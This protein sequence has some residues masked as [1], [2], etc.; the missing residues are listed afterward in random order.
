MRRLIAVVAAFSLL[1]A[2]SAA[3]APVGGLSAGPTAGGFASDNFEY[4]THVPLANDT[5]GA[6]IFGKYLYLT[7][8]RGLNIYDITDPAAPALTGTALLPQTPYFG[9]EDPDTNGKILLLNQHV[10][11][12]EDKTNPV[13]I[14]THDADQHTISCIL[15]CSWAYGSEGAIV[16]L[17]DPTKPKVVGDWTKFTPPLGNTHDVTEVKPGLVMTSTNPLVYLDARKDPTKPKVLAMAGTDDGAYMHANLW[18][19]SGKE[20]FLLVGSETMGPQCGENAGA[21]MTWDTKGWQKSRTFKLT[22]TYR[23]TNG[24]YTDGNSPA[25]LYC[26]HWFETH[27]KYRNGGLV[28]MAWYEHGVRLFDISSAGKISEAGYFIPYAGSTS[29]AYWANDEILY[30]VDYNR[31]LDVL[32]YTGKA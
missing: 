24:L 27:P 3:G 23:V 19:R 14:A 15:D 25:N 8:S 20:R 29:A 4:V 21:F 16:D 9:E 6:R 28:A 22:D 10:V 17:R 13:A 1:L 11:D 5:A 2:G 18:P 7:T 30:S 26:T 31:G 32:R 12:V